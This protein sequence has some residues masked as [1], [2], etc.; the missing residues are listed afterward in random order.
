[1]YRDVN[2]I[3][4]PSIPQHQHSFIWF[5]PR[6][7]GGTSS[8]ETALSVPT[9]SKEL[10]LGPQSKTT[11]PR[12]A[13][14][15]PVM[16]STAPAVITSRR[17]DRCPTVR[18]VYLLKS[19]W[20]KSNGRLVWRETLHSEHKGPEQGS[21]GRSHV[22]NMFSTEFTTCSLLFQVLYRIYNRFSNIM[23]EW[24]NE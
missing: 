10:W 11:P 8:E 9:A 14:Q 17:L 1:M 6:S 3:L 20:L 21:R 22:Y 12:P 18:R 23:N 19:T 4:C 15:I 16:G 5:A 7:S 2:L 13:I 24:S